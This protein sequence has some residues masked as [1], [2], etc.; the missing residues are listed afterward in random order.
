MKLKTQFN[1]FYDKIR[2]KNE[3]EDL[4]EK[5]ETLEEDIK[6]YFPTELEKQDIQVNKSDIKIFDQG[7]YTYH[8]TINTKPYDRDVAVAIPLDIVKYDDPRKIKRMLLDSLCKVATRTVSIKEPC[9]NVSY[10]RD[11][12]E[13]M[14]ID[15][16]LY[17]LVDGTYYLARGK[18]FSDVYSWEEADPK[19]LNGVLKSALEGND[20]LR[21]MVRFIKKWRDIQ[22]EN[23]TRNH[24][25]PPSI[26]LTFLSCDTFVDIYYGNQHDD[27]RELLHIMKEIKGEFALT[28]NNGDLEKAVI[29]KR[30]PVVPNTDIFSKMMSS[31]DSYG[32][33]FYNKLSAA[34]NDL[35][36]AIN[37]DDDAE[38]SRY[39]RKVFGDEFEL[40]EKK[41]CT[42][43]SFLSGREHSF[44]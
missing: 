23:S 8:T 2:I 26:G 34:I 41:A 15:L 32:V 7:S 17:A 19:G 35:T 24:E 43:T 36:D 18:E 30:L 16:P 31:S 40:V 20:Q 10:V 5:R 39:V 27:L 3:T 28:Y 21:R 33:K 38:A 11:G 44:G 1:K 12:K 14:H 29:R 42:D 22:Y 6:S 25:I 9:V 37:A 13:W 4:K